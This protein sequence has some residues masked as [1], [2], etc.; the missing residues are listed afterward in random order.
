[1]S[2]DSPIGIVVS[3]SIARL[4]RFLIEGPEWIVA[5]YRLAFFFGCFLAFGCVLFACVAECFDSFGAYS[6][7]VV[8]DHV[9]VAFFYGHLARDD[10]AALLFVFGLEV[11]IELFVLVES[12][13]VCHARILLVWM[14]MGFTTGLRGCFR[15][16]LM[17]VMLG[18]WWCTHRASMMLG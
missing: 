12:A 7:R 6:G 15:V 2:P 13:L 9:I 11:G 10:F 17:M 1:M 3:W 18:V 5:A 16:C 8:L 14:M 4:V